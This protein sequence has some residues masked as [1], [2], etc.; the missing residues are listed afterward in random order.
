MNRRVLDCQT[1][2][3]QLVGIPCGSTRESKCTACAHRARVLRMQQCAESWH[4][5]HEPEADGHHD[6]ADN[7]N[8]DADADEDNARR[9]RSTKR[10]DDSPDLPQVPVEDRTIGSVFTA[11]DGRQ[12]RPSMFLTLT[13]PS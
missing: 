1:G 4:L 10:R 8:A 12:Y 7:D 5:T 11:P 3:E 13:L 6:Q 9:V 2:D